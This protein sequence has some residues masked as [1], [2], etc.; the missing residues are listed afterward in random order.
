M[1]VVAIHQGIK[2]WSK[3]GNKSKLQWINYKHETVDEMTEE[4]NW[5]NITDRRIA[6]N[7][8]RVYKTKSTTKTLVKVTFATQW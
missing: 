4:Y 8:G 6:C 3:L 2:L 5:Q 7:S 1:R